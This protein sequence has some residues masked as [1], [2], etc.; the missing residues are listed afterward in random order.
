M[1]SQTFDRNVMNLF[2]VRNTECTFFQHF[3]LKKQNTH[4]PSVMFVMDRYRAESSAGPYEWI[5]F[6]V[7]WSSAPSAL[8][9]GIVV[10][11]RQCS[12][13]FSTVHTSF[14][15]R[16]R[17]AVR[18]VLH[19]ERHE[20]RLDC[21]ITNRLGGE[22]GGSAVS[23]SNQSAPTTNPTHVLTH[24]WRWSDTWTTEWQLG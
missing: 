23:S 8:F 6:H 22:V 4:V 12:L 15:S 9:M 17:G 10:L 11:W 16:P 14:P 13:L 20:Q 18:G 2:R 19:M 24:W 21:P 1:F 5:S 7:L 3:P